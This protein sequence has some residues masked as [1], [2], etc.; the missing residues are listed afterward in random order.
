MSVSKKYG[1]YQSVLLSRRQLTVN[2]TLERVSKHHRKR[3]WAPKPESLPEWAHVVD[4]HTHL[5]S[6]VPFA[7]AMSHDAAERGQEPMPVYSVD[8]MI[9]QAVAV[10]VTGMIDCG[11]ELPSLQT[12]IDI[13]QQHPDHVRAAIAIHP[14][15]TVLHGHRGSM[16]PDGLPIV[17]KE[18]HNV[19]FDEALAQVHRLAVACPKEV[20][21]IGETGLDFF[22]TG[23]DA[24]AAQIEAFRA[25]IALSK[26]LGLPM[27]IH[28]RDAHSD[29]IKT[30]LRD[31]APERT[32]FHSFSGDEEMG[33]IAREQEW[34]LS[35]S[36]TVGYKGNDGIRKAARI[37]GLDHIMVE[38]DAPYLTPVPY[39]GQPNAPYMIPYTLAALAEV[40]DMPVQDVAAATRRTT[41]K[42]YGF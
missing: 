9:Q 35:L 28:D 31:G 12:A 13:A 8:E 7:K 10:G 23:E 21:A 14:N 20:V 15:E 37:V 11:C 41:R 36:G 27:Q 1:L 6:V 17:Y 29:V 2:I 25:H 16:G 33:E 40:F 22:R 34:Y 5:A 38:T 24:R 32:V 30:L 39:R 26:E 18:H 19:P 3:N 42:V 4:N